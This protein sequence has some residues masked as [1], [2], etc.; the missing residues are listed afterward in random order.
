MTDISKTDY[1]MLDRPEIL[2]SLFYPRTAA[3]RVETRGQSD[4]FTVTDQR[5]DEAKQHNAKF[6]YN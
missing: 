1:S 4:P 2:N 6:I 5:L 3:A